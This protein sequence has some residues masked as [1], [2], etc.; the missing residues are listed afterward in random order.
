MKYAFIASEAGAISSQG[1][2]PHVGGLSERLLRL[3][4]RTPSVHE[5]A[6]EV[7]SRQIQ[8]AFV[9]GRGVYG[10]PRFHAYLRHQG[11]RC[12]RKRIIQCAG[13]AQ[14]TPP[15][16]DERVVLPAVARKL[17]SSLMPCL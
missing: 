10:S 11:I 4:R 1:V 12:G 9:A 13:V 14:Y 2:V 6:D 7:L 15:R 5:Q 16:I 8:Q 3:R 17:S